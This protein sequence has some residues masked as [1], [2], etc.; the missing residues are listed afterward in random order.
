MGCISFSF[1]FYGPEENDE[2]LIKI[3]KKKNMKEE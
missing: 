3:K 1:K 2:N